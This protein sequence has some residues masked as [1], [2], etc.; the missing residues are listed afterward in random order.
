MLVSANKM[1]NETLRFDKTM[2]IH[3]MYMLMELFNVNNTH[4]L[5]N[6]FSF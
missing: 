1:L 6:L 3:T 2:Q 5:H 4:Y